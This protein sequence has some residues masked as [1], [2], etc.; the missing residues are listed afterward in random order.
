MRQPWFLVALGLPVVGYLLGIGWAE[1]SL[2]Q[3]PLV[4][5]GI[6][7]ADPRDLLRGH[8]VLYRLRRAHADP[9]GDY[10]AACAVADETGRARPPG[11][12]AELP[13]DFIESTHSFYVQQDRAKALERAVLDGRASIR[14]AV[15]SPE[16]VVVR[17]LLVDGRPWQDMP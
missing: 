2:R 11:C 15:V 5:L 13:L 4:E 17:A 6:E 3:A 14:A 12:G 16:R 8:Y 10:T 7:G 1:A 9:G